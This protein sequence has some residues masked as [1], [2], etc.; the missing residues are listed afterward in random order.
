MKNF[1]NLN[2]IKDIN[3]SIDEILDIKNNVGKYQ[4]IFEDKI[5]GLIFFNPSLRTRMST[6]KAS[7]NLGLETFFINISNNIWS[8]EFEDGKIMDS[9][10]VE[11]IKD[12]LLYT[13]PSPRDA[14]T[15][16][17]PSSA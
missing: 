13:S 1:Y 5:I 15:S 6:Y 11:H 12:C 3:Q 7:R 10:K 2:D 17:M 8:L 9:S 4:K 14:L 16:R